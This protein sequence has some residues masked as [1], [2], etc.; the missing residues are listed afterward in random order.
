[1][2]EPRPSEGS[3]S[4]VPTSSVVVP[5][6]ES[7]PE[8]ETDDLEGI[9]AVEP[10][11][12]LLSTDATA[13]EIEPRSN[14]ERLWK[15]GSV[16]PGQS[17][18]GLVYL[19]EE[20][21]FLHLAERAFF[22]QTPTT[23][24]LLTVLESAKV[25]DR[26]RERAASYLVEE[27]QWLSILELKRLLQQEQWLVEPARTILAQRIAD[28][29]PDPHKPEEVIYSLPSHFYIRALALSSDP[30]I[31]ER[32]LHGIELLNPQSPKTL[33]YLMEYGDETQQMAAWQHLQLTKSSGFDWSEAMEWV[34]QT[35]PDET[36]IQTALN[37][38]IE[39]GFPITL[40]WTALPESMQPAYQ[41]ELV[42][43]SK[44]LV[45]LLDQYQAWPGQRPSI[46]T[47]LSEPTWSNKAW[48]EVADHAAFTDP[49]LET[50]YCQALFSRRSLQ[51]LT[52][53]PRFL[54]NWIIKSTALEDRFLMTDELLSSMALD[55]LLIRF[56]TKQ[57]A[58][59]TALI[60]RTDEPGLRLQVRLLEVAQRLTAD[61]VNLLKTALSQNLDRHRL[62]LADAPILAELAEIPDFTAKAEARLLD[63]P[64]AQFLS[65]TLAAYYK[66]GDDA[67]RA[68]L[69]EAFVAKPPL[70]KEV[71][72][73]MS[74]KP[75]DWGLE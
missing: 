74:L 45:E 73:S 65:S 3:L 41:R 7:S 51:D 71:I 48:G 63:L 22:K 75:A 54:S 60:C 1:M 55:S 38:L 56:E 46:L 53:V 11:D 70:A 57:S 59:V 72:R 9:E 40:P 68:R 30:R 20:S 2:P 27:T 31:R 10:V 23:D 43:R 13:P 39:M 44:S 17:E 18:F 34:I 6:Q 62:T 33:R 42:G 28:G 8:F 49:A 29:A 61:Q 36:M 25:A 24:E 66:N 52:N 32:L 67:R 19:Q 12:D 47:R 35:S 16:Q 69:T 15:A 58:I 14:I 21:P 4:E 64:P 37:L 26:I 50:F 5:D